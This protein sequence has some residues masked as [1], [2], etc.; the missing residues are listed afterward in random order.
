MNIFDGTSN[1]SPKRN[2]FDLSH[3]RK[4]TFDM[5]QLVPMLVQEVVP[6]DS[7]RVNST[8]FLRFLA[9]IA[10]VMHKVDVSVFYFFVPYRLLWS[11][12]V[13]FI[14]GGESGVVAPAFPT[15]NVAQVYATAPSYMRDGSLLDYLG[16][17]TVPPA[18]VVNAAYAGNNYGSL[19]IKAYQLIYDQYFR[20][21]NVE[22][23]NLSINFL[24]D[25]AMPVGDYGAMFAM[26]YSMWEKDCFTSCLP[27]TQRGNPVTVPI[28]IQADTTG[29]AGNPGFFRQA[30]GGGVLVPAA[31]QNV[32]NTAGSGALK[33]VGAGGPVSAYYDPN[34]SLT[35]SSL[36]INALRLS[37]RLQEW[38]EKNARGGGRYIETILMHF[39]VMSSDARLQRAEYLGGGKQPVIISEVLTTGGATG[40]TNLPPGT[41]AGHG[42]SLGGS[43]GFTKSVFEEHGLVIGIVRVMPKTAYQNFIPWHFSRQVNTDFFWPSFAHLGEI[44]VR[45]FQVWNDFTSAGAQPGQGAVFGYQSRYYEYKFMPDQISGAFKTS[46]S[47][48]HVG[49]IFAANPTL[50]LAFCQSIPRADIFAVATDPNHLIAQIFHSVDA[51]RP[52]P[53]FGVPN[54]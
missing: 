11:N 15:F 50:N 37:V 7:F 24:G 45:T 13:Q 40:G 51:V 10:P 12:W 52:M 18:G 20:N 25:G 30:P 38:L 28:V 32:Q 49:R 8:V 41:M 35:S 2:K 9:L 5:G 4:L 44:A 6:G 1:K 27:F 53:Y 43:M 17:P 3:E 23:T 21:Q 16:F 36:T 33:A 29:N 47:Y 48:W 54:L 22:T 39:G 26:R 34:G 19:P 31:D 42:M 14:A 46:L